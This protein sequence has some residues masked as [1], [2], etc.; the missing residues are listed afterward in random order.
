[1]GWLGARLP[2]DP[3]VGPRLVLLGAVVAIGLVLD[4]G[5]FHGR[6][7]TVHR[8]VDE[9]WRTRYRGWVWGLGFGAEL[10]VGVVTVVTTS[11]V[12]A[13]WAAAFLS[14]G[15]FAAASVGAAF[16]LSR[17]LPVLSVSRVRRPDQLL[18]VDATLT[19]L[20]APARRA[21]YATGVVLASAAI[22]GGVRW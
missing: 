21:T 15:A 7:P 16:G 9:S 1:V 11:T 14:G 2:G 18:R 3:A 4:A 12:Y 6:L 8:Q 13:T 19:R 20:A 17:A 10:G 22:A 5:L